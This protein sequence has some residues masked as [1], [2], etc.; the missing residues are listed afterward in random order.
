MAS[1]VIA[2]VRPLGPPTPREGQT[3]D[4]YENAMPLG[5]SIDEIDRRNKADPVTDG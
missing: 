4:R 3:A 1:S 5:L 2:G